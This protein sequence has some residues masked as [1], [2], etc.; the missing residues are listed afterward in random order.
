MRDGY[1]QPDY[2]RRY[3]VGTGKR[4]RQLKE[5]E[6]LEK[7]AR[8]KETVMFEEQKPVVNQVTQ[9]AQALEIAK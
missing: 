1:V 4:N 7:D 5:M 3:V 8:E 6:V 2:M 9:V